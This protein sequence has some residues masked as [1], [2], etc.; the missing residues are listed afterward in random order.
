MPVAIRPY[1]IHSGG[2]KVEVVVWPSLQASCS[3]VHDFQQNRAQ[4]SSDRMS[5]SARRTALARGGSSPPT[6]SMPTWPRAAWTKAEVRK[7]APTSMKTEA[8]SCQSV[9]DLKR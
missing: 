9:G 2:A 6:A 4:N 7:V 3:S 1:G 8:S 5:I